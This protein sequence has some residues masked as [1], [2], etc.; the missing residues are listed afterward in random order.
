MA[1]WVH[2]DMARTRV[3]PT[4]IALDED[5]GWSDRGQLGCVTLRHE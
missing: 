5:G 3:A 1:P 4:Y 2:S